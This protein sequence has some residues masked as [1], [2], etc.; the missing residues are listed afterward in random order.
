MRAAIAVA[1]VVARVV[2]SAR[3]SKRTTPVS[4]FQGPLPSIWRRASLFSLRWSSGKTSDCK[5]EERGFDSRPK[6][7]EFC[8]W[9][10]GLMVTT[11]VCRTANGSSI[12]LAP[13]FEIRGVL[14]GEFNTRHSKFIIQ[15]GVW[16]RWIARRITNPEVAR[17]SRAI[18]T[19]P[20]SGA[21]SGGARRAEWTPCHAPSS[22][23]R[24]C[25]ISRPCAR[26][27]ARSSIPRR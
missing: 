13:A 12:L 1:I 6:L 9:G 23:C 7:G 27:R 22:L 20:R 19:N 17:S 21:P 18:P 11:A 8:V 2:A 5:S 25:D 26:S 3:R 14:S 15:K 24:S 16:R 4:P 10:R